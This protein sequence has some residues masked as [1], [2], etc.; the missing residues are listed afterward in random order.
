VRL[1]L[2]LALAACSS[3]S[4]VDA[5]RVDSGSTDAGSNDSGVDGGRAIDAGR[6]SDAGSTDALSDHRDRLIATLGAPCAT[7]A[8][9]DESQRAVFLTITHRFFL[10]QTPDGR[11][12]LDH[13][14]RLHLVLGGGSSGETCGGSENNRLFLGI[15]PYLHGLLVDTWN[16]ARVIGDGGGSTW[17]HTRDSAGPHDPFDASDET[18][19]GLSCTFLFEDDDSRPPTAQAHFFLPG[20]EVAIE[21][22]DISLPA[23]PRMLEIDHDYNCLHDSNPTCRDFID[24]YT[25]NYGD[26]ACAWVPS[27]CAPIGTECFRSVE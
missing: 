16:G 11:S 1:T 7:W 27:A 3:P 10:S 13:V 15:D 2:A 24:R 26:F 6:T 5:G 12:M 14:E 9:F 20:S 21:R 8:S 25:S 23:D 4:P 17:L 19:V 22:G 18:D